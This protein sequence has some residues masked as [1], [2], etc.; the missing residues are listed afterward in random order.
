MA[1]G[2]GIEV[3]KKEATKWILEYLG[4]SQSAGT[5][6]EPPGTTAGKGSARLTLYRNPRKLKA[7]QLSLHI[8]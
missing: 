7:K 3:V 5:K 6:M 2:I 1:L 4:K 8:T